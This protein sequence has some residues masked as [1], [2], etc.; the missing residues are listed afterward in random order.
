MGIKLTSNFSSQRILN[1][2]VEDNQIIDDF[3][4]VRKDNFLLKTAPLLTSKL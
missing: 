1:Y 2:F 3:L 4:T